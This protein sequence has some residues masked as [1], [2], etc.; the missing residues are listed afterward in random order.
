MPQVLFTN[1]FNSGIVYP[2]KT[3]RG[4]NTMRT[5][6][7]LDILDETASRLPDKLYVQ[8]ENESVTYGQCR[9]RAMRFGYALHRELGGARKRP[10]VLFI[11]KSCRCVIS[12]LGVLY[13]GNFYIPMDI[14]MPL[15]RLNS[16][17]QTMGDAVVVTTEKDIP[18]LCKTGY[19]GA[20]LVYEEL[21]AKWPEDGA[22]HALKVV[23]DSMIDTE[24]MYVLFTS[25]STGVPKGVAVMHRSVVDYIETATEIINVE[26]EDILG[27]QTPFYSD[28]SLRDLYMTLKTG[29]S[30]C[31]IPQ[32]YF[33]SPKKL[34]Q[35]LEDHRVT[36]L[37]WVPT[38]FRLISQFDALEKVKPHN[39]KKL[40]YSGESMPIPVYRYWREYYPDA[41]FMQLYGPTEITGVCTFY[42]IMRDYADNERIPIGK[43]F[44]N[45]GILLLDEK[46]HKIASSDT[47]A[48]GEICV[49]GTC[50][51]A[52][53][54]NDP[55]K[56]AEAFVP[57]PTVT[58][59]PSLMY[60]TGD[61]AKYDSEGNLVFI[62][63]KDFQ[64][65]HGGRRIE[66]G[67]IEVAFQAVDGIKAVC[68]VQNRREDKL[69]LYYIGGI[70]EKQMSLTVRDRLPKY[71]IPT[72]YRKLDELPLLPNGKLD[73][74]QMD[75]WANE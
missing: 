67:E 59:Y 10:I 15:A 50:L 34:L 29:A 33:M 45:T 63:R 24:L 11:D 49:Y 65:K 3:E 38:A 57:N 17:L 30:V 43:P 22:A 25:G 27:N 48:A 32:K 41:E 44:P 70:G 14:K 58:G 12:M 64:I 51:A 36:T 53:Y 37:M 6:S 46:G 31:L 60:R 5:I 54:Y 62:S 20:V 28:V 19:E 42:H 18:A 68:C 13:S 23:R 8:D 55:G 9:A 40:I 16:I 47:S 71:M 73:R 39:L 4:R 35:Y 26:E 7:I 74:K 66:L 61:L 72:E 2:V 69:V 75:R 1:D 56:T 52:G 21:V